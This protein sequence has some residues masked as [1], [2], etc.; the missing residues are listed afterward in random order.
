M[1]AA[2][3]CVMNSWQPLWYAVLGTAAPFLNGKM[4]TSYHCR[5]FDWQWILNKLE[6]TF[7]TNQFGCLKKRS[8]RHALVSVLH[9]WQSALDRGESVRALFVD[10]SMA[11][12]WVN[13]NILLHKLRSQDIPGF[14]LKWF[15]SVLTEWCQRVRV[16]GIRSGW[17]DL[18]DSIPKGS[19]LGLLLFLLLVDDLNTNCST[20]IWQ[21]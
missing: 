14:L 10:F 13:H 19:L 17:L 20:R 21:Q 7:D 2:V 11:F 1:L 15:H 16:E 12:D 18:K 8:T 6:A 3:V 5:I 9:L 4:S